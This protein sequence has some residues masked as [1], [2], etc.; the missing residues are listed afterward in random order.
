MSVEAFHAT[1]VFDYRTVEGLCHTKGALHCSPFSPPNYFGR[2]IVTKTFSFC[3]YNSISTYGQW[4]ESSILC[5]IGS[6]NLKYD[7]CSSSDCHII[8]LS[9]GF[10]LKTTSGIHKPERIEFCESKPDCE[11]MSI[12]AAQ[13]LANLNFNAT[14]A[15]DWQAHHT[16]TKNL[17][18]RKAKNIFLV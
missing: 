15:L 11:E 6:L 16:F 1:S 5:A 14:K 8:A 4:I 12:R 7:I 2:P 13:P 18:G 9:R 3:R 10:L 17:L